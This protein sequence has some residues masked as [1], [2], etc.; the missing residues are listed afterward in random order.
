MKNIYIYFLKDPIS[1]EIKYIGKTI[2]IKRRLS[3]YISEARKNKNK[4]HVLNWINSLLINGQSPIINIIEICNDD[5]WQE[6]EIYW[7]LYY[8][9]L[10]TKLCN[11]SNG[12]LGGSGVKNFS[13]EEIKR[14]SLL[15]SNKRSKYNLEL[16]LKIWDLIKENKTHKEINSLFPDYSRQMDFGIKNGRQWN[17]ITGMPITKGLKKERKGYIVNKGL[18]IVRKTINNKK[19]TIFSSRIKEDILEYLEIDS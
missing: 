16:K 8:R 2:N 9:N 18:Y 7:I 12:G 10:N 6:R 13:Q 5:N 3:L 11:I 1:N 4:R 14:R 19:V 15:L 17:N